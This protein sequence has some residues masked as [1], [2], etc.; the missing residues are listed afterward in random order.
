MI[1][2]VP[3]AEGK[4][5]RGGEIGRH[6]TFRALCL[7]WHGGSSP[8]HGI[9]NLESSTAV[10]STALRLVQQAEVTRT[11]HSLHT[12]G[13]LQLG[14]N[15]AHMTLDSR[16]SNDQLVRNLSVRISSCY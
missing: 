11:C 3:R 14:E 4:F 15:I 6:A 7:N 5:S 13:H 8:P 10:D 12:I 1:I 16:R 9:G 2:H